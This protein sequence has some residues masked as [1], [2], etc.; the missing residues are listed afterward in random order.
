MIAAQTQS[1]AAARG[2]SGETIKSQGA[3]H[4]LAALTKR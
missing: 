1:S 2:G 3:S 4:A